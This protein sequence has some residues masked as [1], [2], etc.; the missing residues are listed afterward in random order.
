MILMQ[1][2][3]VLRYSGEL[4]IKSPRIKRQWEKLL[5]EHVRE[6]VGSS[7]DIRIFHSRIL[8]YLDDAKNLNDVEKSL[9][10]LFG[11]SSISSGL[12][13]RTGIPEI[14]KGIERLI[15]EGM[16]KPPL[17]FEV[18][19]F[20]KTDYRPRDLI[21]ILEEMF[22][23]SQQDRDE[24][25]S[26][27]Y[28]EIRGEKSF[29]LRDVISGP[30]GLPFGT[31]DKLACL[32]SGG[33]DSTLSSWMAMRRG[34]PIIGVYIP[35][36][37]EIARQRAFKAAVHLFSNWTPNRSGKLYVIPIEEILDKIS[38]IGGDRFSHV[39]FKRYALRIAEIIAIYEGAAGIVTG[40]LSGEH[41]SQTVWNLSIITKAINLPVYRPV[42]GFDK[43]EVI[44]RLKEIDP[45]LFEI[46]NISVEECSRIIPKWPLTRVNPSDIKRLEKKIGFT[47]PKDLI[48]LM[49]DEGSVLRIKNFRIESVDNVKIPPTIHSRF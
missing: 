36:G 24:E 13:V 2:V 6:R 37:S 7:K 40:E 28:L 9:M 33:P 35:L 34:S 45:Q 26:T 19:K 18:Y 11:F 27:I 21:E 29:L 49:N 5:L 39:L 17:K 4:A 30:G 14:R 41:A 20:V 46:V 23:P 47:N 43:N 12:E 32:M 8:V 25:P 44:L 31:Q 3:V 38:S 16:V 22:T 48:K 42:F 10:T 15:D 1:Y